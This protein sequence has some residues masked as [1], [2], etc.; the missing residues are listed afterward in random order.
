MLVSLFFVYSLGLAFQG[1]K[2][3]LSLV[4]GR[5]R[6]TRDSHLMEDFDV[7]GYLVSLNNRS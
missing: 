3:Q 4:Q 5:R 2:R 6:A 7:I 1:L